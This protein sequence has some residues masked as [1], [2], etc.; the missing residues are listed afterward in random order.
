MI[1]SVCKFWPWLQDLSY[2][3]CTFINYL[4]TA[5]IFYQDV[6]ITLASK[7]LKFKIKVRSSNF[8][9]KHFIHWSIAPAQL[10]EILKF[11][12]SHLGLRVF[13]LCV[14]VIKIL[15]L[16]FVV[17]WIRIAPVGSYIWML[18]ISKEQNKSPNS[19]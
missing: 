4:Q 16:N 14:A 1:F 3:M 15:R 13:F 18:S 2:F 19:S 5:P 7:I 9:S 11:P 10:P 12:I 8:C 6:C 17:V